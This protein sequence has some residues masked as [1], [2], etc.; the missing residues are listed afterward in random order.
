MILGGQ[1]REAVPYAS[2]GFGPIV[3]G[4]EFEACEH[5][6]KTRPE[7]GRRFDRVRRG[8]GSGAGRSTESET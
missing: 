3:P 7:R 1:R 5:T 2:F 4:R 6:E 8:P